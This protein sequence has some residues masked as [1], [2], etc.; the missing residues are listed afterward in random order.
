MASVPFDMKPKLAFDNGDGDPKANVRPADS[1][2]RLN[3]FTDYQREVSWPRGHEHP[4]KET[5]VRPIH[6]RNGGQLLCKLGEARDAVIQVRGVLQVHGLAQNEIAGGLL[7][8][9]HIC[10][11]RRVY[12]ERTTDPES[13]RLLQAESARS[14]RHIA[15]GSIF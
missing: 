15:R 8:V 14:R 13:E 10:Y 3:A 1:H 9:L 2:D 12:V 5:T 4:P 7:R 6:L 11:G